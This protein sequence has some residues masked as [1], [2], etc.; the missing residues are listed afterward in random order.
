MNSSLFPFLN[1]PILPCFTNLHSLSIADM[2]CTGFEALT[3]LRELCT[4][5]LIRTADE[6]RQNEKWYSRYGRYCKD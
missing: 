3:E 6:I 4:M 5:I 1:L 2:E